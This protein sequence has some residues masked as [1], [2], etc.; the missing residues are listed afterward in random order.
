ME[1]RVAEPPEVARAIQ[2]PPLSWGGTV[3]FFGCGG[4]LLYLVV[5]ILV[6]AA[7]ASSGAEPVL[8]WFLFAGS[9]FL[10]PLM[11]AAAW[12]L[13]REGRRTWQELWGGRL[14]FRPMGGG[15]WLWTVGALV[16]IGVLS[17]A[18]LAL[19]QAIQGERPPMFFVAMEPL[20]P[21]RYWVLAAWLPFFALNIL[22]EEFVWRG[23]VLPRQEVTFGR[24]A[25]LVNGAAHLLL[26]LPTGVP[27]LVALWPTALILPY[28]VQ[29]RRNTWIGVI[30]HGA[31]N[32][33]G[34]VAVAFG[35]V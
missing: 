23:V 17:A 7:S 14:R 4:L 35:L 18:S 10:I 6:P 11:V 22:G 24:T 30:V 13:R 9:V 3:L 28:V 8:L 32:G 33:P 16:A 12:L 34:F 25:W 31:L 5:H 15:D 21:G 2:P 1:V 27:I 19:L 26:H 20:A 29:R